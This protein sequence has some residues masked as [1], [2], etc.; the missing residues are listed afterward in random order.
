MDAA[1]RL[2]SE[3]STEVER[4]DI[5]AGVE[6]QGVTILLSNISN[7]V[8]VNDML[9]QESGGVGEWI[10]RFFA[11]TMELRWRIQRSVN[12][13]NQSL[14]ST[15][16]SIGDPDKNACSEAMK[17]FRRLAEFANEI[18]IED[19]WTSWFPLSF[20]S[21]KGKLVCVSLL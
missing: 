5:W 17:E 9:Q 18:R 19:I 11:E 12:R 7:G 2:P 3:G 20:A 6:R 16:R 10:T 13:K 14:R 15:T 4:M 8:E 1:E 21:L